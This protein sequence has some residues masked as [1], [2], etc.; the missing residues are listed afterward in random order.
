M[1][2]LNVYHTIG[3]GGKREKKVT[4]LKKKKETFQ[5]MQ[6]SVSRVQENY[7]FPFL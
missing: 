1:L 4:Q 6:K 5:K 7:F 2:I 3:S